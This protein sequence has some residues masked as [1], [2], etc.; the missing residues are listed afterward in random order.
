MKGKDT[1]KIL[2]KAVYT[3]LSGKD[4]KQS[5]F[6]VANFLG[7]LRQHRLEKMIPKILKELSFASALRDGTANSGVP[8]K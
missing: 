6:V 3:A 1:A 8:K 4:K 2:A 7:Y 5:D